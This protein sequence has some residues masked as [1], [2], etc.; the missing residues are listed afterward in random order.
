MEGRSEID[1][2]LEKAVNTEH[3]ATVLTENFIKECFCQ[4]SSKNHKPL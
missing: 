1:C 4:P 3:T 2:K